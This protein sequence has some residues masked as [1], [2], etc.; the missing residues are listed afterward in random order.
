[1][2]EQQEVMQSYNSLPSKKVR[3]VPFFHGSSTTQT[4]FHT[5][6]SLI[7]RITVDPEI[8][9]GKAVIT[10]TRIT[11]QNILELVNEG[12][13]FDQIVKNYY[14]ELKEEDLRACQHY[15][16]APISTSG[17]PIST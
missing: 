2:L 4:S 3:S 9:F 1:M 13:T 7:G 16:N 15:Y 11:V 12:L 14:P 6:F 17:P 10:G 5:D 8:H